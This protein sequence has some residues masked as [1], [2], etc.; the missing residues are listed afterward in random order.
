MR[1]MSNDGII[2]RNVLHDIVATQQ[3]NINCTKTGP[4]KFSYGSV[5]HTGR[6]KQI[7]L[8]DLIDKSS[9]DDVILVVTE[10]SSSAEDDKDCAV[11]LLKVFALHYPQVLLV[12]H[13]CVIMTVIIVKMQ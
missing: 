10:D 5:S 2:K 1:F 11:F 7:T 12:N 6:E 4:T 9:L 3:N 8:G 13:V